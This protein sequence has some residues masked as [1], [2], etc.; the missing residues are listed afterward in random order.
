M[1]ALQVIEQALER[2]TRSAEDRGSSQNLGILDNHVA[3]E[4]HVLS[5]SKVYQG[6]VARAASG[7]GNPGKSGEM[8]YLFTIASIHMLQ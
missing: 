7:E 1:A 2:H 6:G 5:C 3:R 8:I 4:R